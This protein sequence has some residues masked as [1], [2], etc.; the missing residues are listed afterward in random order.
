M[1]KL[2]VASIITLAASSALMAGVN[3][4][5]C[6]GCHGAN[7][8]KKALGKSRVVA[9]LTHDEIATALK[10]YKAGTY[11]GAMKG[12]MK[13]QVGKYSVADLEAFSKTIGK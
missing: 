10:G 13:G 12:V 5:A 2:V 8:E 3:P 11:G 9:N 7:W 4:A 1:K 6:K